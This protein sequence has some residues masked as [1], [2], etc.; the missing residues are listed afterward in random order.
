VILSRFQI[1][2]NF[3]KVSNIKINIGITFGILKKHPDWGCF[4]W[5]L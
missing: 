2:D 5:I 1:L 3:P 4:D